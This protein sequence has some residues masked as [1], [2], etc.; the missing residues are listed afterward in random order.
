VPV[1]KGTASRVFSH[2]PLQCFLFWKGRVALYAIL[3][4]LEIKEGD[5]IILPAFTCVVA[6]NP[7]IY[8]G[9]NPVYVD[10]D[11]TTYNIDVS[12]IERKITEKTRAILAQNTF[13]LAP[14]LDMILEVANKYKLMVIEDRAHGF[15][16][17]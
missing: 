9:A 15:A 1:T 5:E 6:V 7:I 12:M 2:S 8:L 11:P 16:V 4:T 13:G 3:K 14:D 10:I 17:S